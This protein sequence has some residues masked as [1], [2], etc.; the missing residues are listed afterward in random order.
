MEGFTTSAVETVEQFEE[1]ASSLA[2]GV[3]NACP[4]MYREKPNNQDPINVAWN[5]TVEL[6]MRAM[7]AVEDLGN[8]LRKEAGV[9]GPGPTAVFCYETSDSPDDTEIDPDGNGSASEN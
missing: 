9:V 2:C 6:T 4:V 8:L 7:N 3:F 5:Q 1:E